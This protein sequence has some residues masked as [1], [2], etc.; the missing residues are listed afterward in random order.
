M[1]RS[2]SPSSEIENI[3]KTKVLGIQWDTINDHL[4]YSFEDFVESFKS[5]LL[6]KPS[7]LDLIANFYDPVGLIQPVIIKLKLLFK[8]FV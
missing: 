7:I 8:T 4:I 6:T 2:I 1:E 5:V 3:D